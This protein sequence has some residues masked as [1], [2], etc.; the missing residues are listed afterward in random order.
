[1]EAFGLDICSRKNKSV[2]Y[3][4]GHRDFELPE[5]K[6]LVDAVQ[7]SKFI[8]HKKSLELIKKVEGL[9]SVHD[10]KLLQR[11][12][13]VTNRVK[14]Y[15]E[16]IYYNVD[17]IHLSISQNVQIEFLYFEWTINFGTTEKISKKL[18][19]NGQKYCVSPLA[20][21]WDDENYYLVALDN[22][23]NKTKHYRVDKM[24]NID[25][26]EIPRVGVENT[27][28]DTAIYSKSMFGMFGGEI[29]DVK[30]KVE[31]SLIG[32]IVDR[33]GKELF[34]NKAD[35]N[36]FYVTINVA[37]SAQF[38][39]WLCGLGTKVQIICPKNVAKNYKKHVKSIAKEYKNYD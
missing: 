30:L 29:I 14:T 3:Y 17:K 9:A 28:F 34:I 5:L 7:S 4:I 21:V 33:F 18:K 39:G 12:V 1:M 8:T 36:S 6:L 32:V 37:E 35:E 26:T 23:S 16:K 11:Q 15:N 31:N 20:L 2:T 22:N 19:H 24:E 13:Y 27:N 25:I 38:Y 10:G